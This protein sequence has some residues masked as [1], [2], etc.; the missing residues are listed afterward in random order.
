VGLKALAMDHGPPTVDGARC[1]L[2]SDEHTTIARADEGDRLP[3][4]G[5]RVRVWPAHVDPTVAY[6]PRMYVVDGDA[7]VDEWPVDLRGW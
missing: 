1:V 5:D 3:K 4:V 6:H 2:V 7:V